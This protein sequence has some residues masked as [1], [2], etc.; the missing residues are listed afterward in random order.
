[1]AVP[2]DLSRSNFSG[3]WQPKLTWGHAGQG[4]GSIPLDSSSTFSIGLM[5]NDSGRTGMKTREGC[6]LSLSVLRFFYILIFFVCVGVVCS[7]EYRYRGGQKSMLDP[8]ELEL[9]PVMSYL[10]WALGTKL[11]SSARAVYTLNC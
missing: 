10:M 7:L 9:Q 6:P 11:Q 8:L 4:N 5:A 3:P 1:M 2:S